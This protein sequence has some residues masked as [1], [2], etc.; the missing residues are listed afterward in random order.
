MA[1]HVVLGCTVIVWGGVKGDE[2]GE[3][4]QETLLLSQSLPRD[5]E[6]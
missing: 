1:D 6:M 2:D 5:P 3:S 4:G